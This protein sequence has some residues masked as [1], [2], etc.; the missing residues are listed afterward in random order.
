MDFQSKPHNMKSILFIFITIAFLASCEKDY[1]HDTGL[2][3][4]Y[5]DC[6]MMDY[7][8]SDHNNWDSI[9]VAIEHA[10]LTSIFEG[11]NPGYKEITFF[12]PTNTSIRKFF[13]EQAGETTYQS[14]REMPVELV[15]DMIL[16][17]LVEGKKRKE[18][19]DHE[20]KGTLTGGTEVY[21][22]NNIKLRVYRTRTE[23]NGIPDI[24]PEELKI[25]AITS[26]QMATIASA[27]IETNNGVVHSLANKFTWVEL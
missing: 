17:Y 25:H 23:F 13:L 1:R 26:G 18:S 24:G 7:L 27:D 11:T 16:A 20:I 15:R 9:V 2:A 6:S 21:S 14:I 19:F 22:L 10:G 4:G 8:R 12:G 3:D 5:H